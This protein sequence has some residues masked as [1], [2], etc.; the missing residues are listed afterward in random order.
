MTQ[1]TDLIKA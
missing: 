1:T